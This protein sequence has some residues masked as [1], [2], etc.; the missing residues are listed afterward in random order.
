MIIHLT[1]I[2]LFRIILAILAHL[3]FHKIKITFPRS[4]KNCNKILMIVLNL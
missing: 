2:L 3:C 4:L 1:I